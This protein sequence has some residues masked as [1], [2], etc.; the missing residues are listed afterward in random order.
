MRIL[1]L[2]DRRRERDRDNEVKY[3]E[4]VGI[5]DPCRCLQVF[6]V[7][8]QSQY[9]DRSIFSLGTV[10]S[11]TKRPSRVVSESCRNLSSLIIE[12]FQYHYQ[13]CNTSHESRT[14]QVTV[15]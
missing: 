10:V 2:G 3:N 12:S 11:D 15:C 14:G 8:V 6:F 13:S 4:Y 1:V 5:K 7:V 9:F